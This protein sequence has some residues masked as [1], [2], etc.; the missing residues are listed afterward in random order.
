LSIPIQSVSRWAKRLQTAGWLRKDGKDYALTPKAK[1]LTP[2]AESSI[3]IQS[4]PVNDPQAID[5][6]KVLSIPAQGDRAFDH[7]HDQMAIKQPRYIPP[8]IPILHVVHRFHRA[9]Y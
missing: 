6:T 7:D 9:L 8:L 2:K 4:A 1:K 3:G 5:P